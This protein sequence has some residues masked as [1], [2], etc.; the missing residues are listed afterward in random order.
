MAR[1]AHSAG[2]VVNIRADPSLRDGLTRMR[3]LAGT[4]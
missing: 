3:N 1:W 2:Q 4:K